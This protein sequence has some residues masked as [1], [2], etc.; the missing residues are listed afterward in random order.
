[1]TLY[2]AAAFAAA[3][4]IYLYKRRLLSQFTVNA[5]LGL[6]CCVAAACVSP[7]LGLRFSFNFFTAAASVLFGPA[8]TVGLLAIM[9]LWDM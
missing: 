8:G 9:Y 5:L 4:L 1:M 7:S 3:E 6:L 2:I